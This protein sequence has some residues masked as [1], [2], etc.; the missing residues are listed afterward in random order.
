MFA[1]GLDIQLARALGMPRDV[2]RVVVGH[3][4]CSGALVG[5]RQALAAL[6][7]R[8]GARARAACVELCSPHLAGTRP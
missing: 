5:V 4:G 3:M 8:P 2:R 1:P 6:A 7:V